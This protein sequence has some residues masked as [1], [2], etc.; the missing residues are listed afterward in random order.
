MPPP[1]TTAL[2]ALVNHITGGHIEAEGYSGAAS[3]QPM[4]VNFGLFPAV[5][6][7]KPEGVKR[8]RGT[9]KAMAKRK[10]ISSRA[11]DDLKAWAN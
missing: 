1:A 8:W 6:V 4:N 9:E 2:G 3:F 10:A 11:L 7:R 5:D